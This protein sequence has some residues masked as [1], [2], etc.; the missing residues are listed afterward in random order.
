MVLNDQLLGYVLVALAAMGAVAIV[1]V[2]ARAR[3]GASVH[4]P[5]GIHVPPGSWL[6][7]LWAVAASLV[8]AGLA[9]KPEDQVLNWF[10]A[11]PGFILIVL[12]AVSSVRAAGREW[13]ATEHGSDDEGAG[14]H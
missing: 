9:F 5:A 14:H 13:R 10:F 1:A 8:G 7:V 12:A 3:A 11:I 2:A 4:P 6:P